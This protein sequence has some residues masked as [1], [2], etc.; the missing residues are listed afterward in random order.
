MG[1]DKDTHGSPVPTQWESRGTVMEINHQRSDICMITK[2]SFYKNTNQF[3]KVID[4]NIPFSLH[5]SQRIDAN[6]PFNFG[7]VLTNS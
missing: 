3:G 7:S 1:P 2:I 5:N 4:V 6:I